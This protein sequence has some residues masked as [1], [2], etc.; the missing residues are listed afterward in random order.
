LKNSFGLG[1]DQAA[2]QGDILSALART[3]EQA[4]AY[5]T[6]AF[7][8]TYGQQV[9]ASA[10]RDFL[11]SALVAMG[12][13][14]LITVPLS[15]HLSDRIG[16][17]GCRTTWLLAW[18]GAVPASGYVIAGY[19]AFCAVVNIIATLLMLD[20]TNKDNEGL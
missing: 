1:G 3:G 12:I 20:H 19:I 5:I 8:F 15:G 18:T 11:L 2:A 7:I 9:L 14:P 17:T 4:P 16:R 10:A 6:L 13:L